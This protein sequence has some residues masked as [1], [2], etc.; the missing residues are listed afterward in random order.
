MTSQACR[1]RTLSFKLFLA[2]TNLNA[3]GNSSGGTRVRNFCSARLASLKRVYLGWGV[4]PTHAPAVSLPPSLN[5][6]T[7]AAG[8]GE[9]CTLG[10]TLERLKRIGFTQSR[11]YVYVP[12]ECDDDDDDGINVAHVSINRSSR[13][14]PRENTDAE[15]PT[16]VLEQILKK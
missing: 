1:L 7:H 8:R 9:L 5:L 11:L 2:I 16:S 12:S 13:L 6:P 3:V 14:P 4:S 15:Y 10:R